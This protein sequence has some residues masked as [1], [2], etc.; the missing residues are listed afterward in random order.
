[1]VLALAIVH[2]L[3]LGQSMSFDEIAAALGRLAKKYLCV[4]FVAIDDPMITSDPGFFPAYSASPGS[5]GWYDRENFVRA[6]GAHFSTIE[7]APSHPQSRTLL[8]CTR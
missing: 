5:F 3:A 7:L 4:E 8:I 1:M 2:H 6:L